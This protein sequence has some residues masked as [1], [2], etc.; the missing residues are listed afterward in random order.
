MQG[1]SQ[2]G[3]GTHHREDPVNADKAA[4]QPKRES[5]DDTDP[6]NVSTFS[7]QNSKT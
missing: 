7:L 2:E 3:Y 6:A 1:S 4:H 5:S